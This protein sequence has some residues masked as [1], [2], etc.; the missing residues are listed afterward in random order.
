M[1]LKSAVRRDPL[2]RADIQ[3][4]VPEKVTHYLFIYKYNKKRI[5][6]SL[7]IVKFFLVDTYFYD[8]DE[9]LETRRH[10]AY[11]SAITLKNI[12]TVV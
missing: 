3:N 11:Q 1:N 8:V 7:Y 4:G 6:H 9:I 5:I 10:D 2:E 12:L